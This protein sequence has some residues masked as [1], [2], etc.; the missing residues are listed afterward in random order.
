VQRIDIRQ[1]NLFILRYRKILVALGF[2][3]IVW[4]ISQNP[5]AGNLVLIAN[6][7]VPA[8]SALTAEQF[9]LATISDF[10]SANYVS[11][12]SDLASNFSQVDIAPGSLLSR[13]SITSDKVFNNRIDV[14]VALENQGQINPGTHLHLWS[15]SEEIGRLISSEAIVR[16]S[17]TDNYGTRLTVSIPISDEYAVMQSQGIKVSLVN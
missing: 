2:S 6:Q 4:T 16:K 10:D 12:Y 7:F 3:F 5:P 14:F 11:K 8:N 17:E 15:Q 13:D 9:S 1:V